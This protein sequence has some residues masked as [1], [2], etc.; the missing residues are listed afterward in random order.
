MIQNWPK[1]REETEK[2]QTIQYDTLQFEFCSKSK[3]NMVEKF[4]L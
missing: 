1:T 4:S 2:Y 3:L